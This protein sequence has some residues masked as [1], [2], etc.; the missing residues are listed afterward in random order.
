MAGDALGEPLVAHL[1]PDGPHL[2]FG[3]VVLGVGADHEGVAGVPLHTD[4]EATELLTRAVDLLR[5]EGIRVTGS[6][7]RAPYR[8]VRQ[9][10][11]S[12]AED[13]SADA[14]VVGT[15]RKRRL[16]RL[17]SSHVREHIIMLSS[18]P[19]IAAPAPL[20]LPAD[21]RLVMAEMLDVER[22]RTRSLSAQ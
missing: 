7:R 19:V 15:R 2:G 9:H 14:I 10:I 18:L 4:A 22:D 20:D 8:H 21:G 1:V 3:S 6:A 11:V 13:F 17:F 5:A 12:S 16:G